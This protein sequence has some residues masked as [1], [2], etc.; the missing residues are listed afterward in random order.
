M[1]AP[2]EQ[3]PNELAWIDEH[4]QLQCFIKRARD[5]LHLCGYVQ[6]PEGHPLHGVDASQDV[7]DAVKPILAAVMNGPVGKR[8]SIDLLCMAGG[9]VHAGNLFD[10]HGGVTY[11]GGAYWA[12]DSGHWYG[13]DCAH[14]DD[15]SPGMSYHFSP[16]LRATLVYR[17]IEY[18]KAECASLAQQ[19]RS[20]SA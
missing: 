1:T 14:C 16:D 7:P 5:M 4:T 15:L 13:F 10:V 17:D 6:I 18:V 2:W 11:S 12:D 8:S 3:E 19:I 9:I 20:M